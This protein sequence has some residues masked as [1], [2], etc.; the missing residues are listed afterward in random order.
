MSTHREGAEGQRN[1]GGSFYSKM[2]K[3]ATM[4]PKQEAAPKTA[5]RTKL[6]AKVEVKENPEESCIE[7]GSSS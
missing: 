6:K 3:E 2:K 4:K 5:P 1:K 7:V